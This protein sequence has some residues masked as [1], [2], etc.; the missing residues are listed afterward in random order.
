MKMKKLYAD[1]L[2]KINFINF[3][4]ISVLFWQKCVCFVCN[5]H[6][7]MYLV[8]ELIAFCSTL[9]EKK[10]L[11]NIL[12]LSLKN[13]VHNKKQEKCF[14]IFVNGTIFLIAD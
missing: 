5:F 14:S 9:P 6:R 7:C 1:V 11:A 12:F 8:I 2:K 10:A 4:R 3:V 13:L